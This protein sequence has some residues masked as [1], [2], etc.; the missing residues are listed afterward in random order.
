MVIACKR[1]MG[2]DKERIVEDIQK[3]VGGF[4]VLIKVEQKYF[5]FIK[6]SK[7]IYFCNKKYKNY[8]N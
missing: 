8:N 6:W 5:E 3:S 2:I 1:Q 7:E 4:Y